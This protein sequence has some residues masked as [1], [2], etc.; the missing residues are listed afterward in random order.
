MAAFY[1]DSDM[2]KVLER[3]L[4]R[5]A[6]KRGLSKKLARLMGSVTEADEEEESVTLN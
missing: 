1:P 2:P 5:K 4:N 3:K 6:K